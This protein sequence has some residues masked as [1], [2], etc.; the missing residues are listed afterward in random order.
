MRKLDRALDSLSAQLGLSPQSRA[1]LGWIVA[2]AVNKEVQTESILERLAR[3]DA[4]GSEENVID[5]E[6]LDD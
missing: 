2:D 4:Y 1:R 3:R 6:I 5:V